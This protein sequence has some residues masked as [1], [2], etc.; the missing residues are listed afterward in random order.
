[1]QTAP[2]ERRVQKKNGVYFSKDFFVAPNGG[3]TRR[4]A[5]PTGGTGSEFNPQ[6]AVRRFISKGSRSIRIGL[7][8]CE[9]VS[10]TRVRQ[11]QMRV[12]EVDHFLCMGELKLT[13]V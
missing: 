11:L 12:I 6:T 9:V 7:Q 1:M 3:P 13:N 4:G 8:L 10:D 5:G 2:V